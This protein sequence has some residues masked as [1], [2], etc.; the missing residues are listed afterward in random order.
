[1][2][3]RRVLNDAGLPE[4]LAEAVED[5]DLD[6]YI[7]NCQD[8]MLKAVGSGLGPPVLLI[9]SC[10]AAFGPVVSPSPRRESAGELFD[11]VRHPRLRLLLR[12]QTQPSPATP[13][14]PRSAMTGTP[15]ISTTRWKG[16]K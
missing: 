15:H 5:V 9:D 10:A 7:H 12:T 2:L 14:R 11:A 16:S 6:A 1:V 13:G 4:E 8:E 3:L